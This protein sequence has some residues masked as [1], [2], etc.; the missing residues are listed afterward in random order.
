MTTSWADEKKNLGRE[1]LHGLYRERMFR[2]W[3]RDRPEGWELVSGRWSP[4]YFS[5]R[6]VPSQ[7]EMFRLVVRA[8]AALIKNRTPDANRLVGLAATGIPIAAAVGYEIGIS[9]GFNRKLPNVRSLEELAK[10]VHKY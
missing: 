6:D 5:M 10:E 2:T 9:M 8:T 3:L 1:L 7:P 4:F